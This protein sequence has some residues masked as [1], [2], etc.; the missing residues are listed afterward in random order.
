MAGTVPIMAGTKDYM[1]G[2]KELLAGTV[3][4]M[5]GTEELLAGTVH[6][7]AGTEE[8]MAGTVHYMAG[9]GETFCVSDAAG[10][11]AAYQQQKPAP[12]AS[13]AAPGLSERG[14]AASES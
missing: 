13:G 4:Y 9:T 7:M 8:L 14:E 12:A 1:A 10:A 2:T 5:A 6:Y 11:K 3:H